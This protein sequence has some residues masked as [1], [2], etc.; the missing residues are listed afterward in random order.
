MSEDA[1]GPAHDAAAARCSTPRATTSRAARADLALFES[2][3]RL[4]RD[5]RRDRCPHEHRALGALLAGRLRAAVVARRRARRA[6]DF[7]AAKGAA[8]RACSTRCASTGRSSAGRREPFLHPGRSAR[9]CCAGGERPSAGSASCTRS[10]RARGTSTAAR[11]VRARPRPRRRRTP[12]PCRATATSRASRALRQDLAVVVPD[13]VPAARRARRRRAGRAASCWPAR[14]SSTSTAARRWARAACRSRSHLDLPRARPHADRRGRRAACASA[15]VARAARRARGR[16][17]CLSVASVAGASGFA[18][19]LAARAAS[20]ATRASSSAAVTAPLGRRPARST[21]STRTTACRWCSRSSTSTRAR[22]RRRRDRRLPARRR[23]A[24]RRRRCASAACASS[25]CPPTSAC[26]TVD[27]YERWYVAHPRA[28]AARRGR[29]R[30]ARAAPRRRSRGADLVA[31]PGCFPTAALLALAPLARAGLIADVVIDAKTGVSGAGRDADRDARTSSSVDENV[32]ALRGRRGHRHTPEID[33]ELAALGAPIARR[34]CRTSCRSTRASS[35]PATCT[36]DARPVDV[37]A[38]L[39]A[40]AY[41][42]EPFVELVDRP[43]GV[44]DVRETNFCRIHARRRRAH[45][46]G[47]SSSRRS[48]TSGRARRRRRSRTS[49]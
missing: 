36:L 11:A 18:G 44:R 45:R 13:D 2:G 26:A 19:A 39:R 49:T 1:V 16:A 14:A 43:P 17:A 4:P 15:I 28:R 12:T 37:D 40:T 21:T 7:F 6:A 48:T 22:R 8:R 31:N 30:P 46:Q 27:V 20:S 34:S 9:R 29:L 41:A 35:S 10:S 23:R 32:D 24:G 3:A 47:A 38:L 5:R 25:T 33:Q 42:D